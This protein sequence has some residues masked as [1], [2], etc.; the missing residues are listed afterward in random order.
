VSD[1]LVQSFDQKIYEI[2]HF[3]ISEL[4]CEF[5]QIPRT[6]LYDIIVVRLGYHE[7]CSRRFPKM[8]TGAYKKQKIGSAF[9]YFLEKCDVD[10][11]VFLNH[12]VR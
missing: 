6:V 12:I 4:S 2:W 8:L 7:F 9:G 5:S 3:I 11:D 1:D 10:G